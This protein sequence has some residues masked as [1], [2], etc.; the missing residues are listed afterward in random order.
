MHEC[1]F[2]T[3]PAHLRFRVLGHVSIMEGLLADDDLLRV[4]LQPLAPSRRLSPLV[5]VVVVVVVVVARKIRPRC[6]LMQGRG[7]R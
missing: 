2:I 3:T 5:V 1:I 7:P 4:M 6:S